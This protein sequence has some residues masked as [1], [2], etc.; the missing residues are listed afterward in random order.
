MKKS[1]FIILLASLSLGCATSFKGGWKD[2]KAY[3]NTFYNAKQ[4]YEIGLNKNLNQNIVYNPELP[5]RILEKP[6][7]GGTQE[8]D[9]AIDKSADI[10]RKHNESKWVDDAIEIIGKSYFFKQDYFSADQK[11]IELYNTSQ[12]EEKKQIAAVWK[13]RTLYEMEQTSQAIAYLREQVTALEESWQNEHLSMAKVVLAEA[14]IAEENWEAALIELEPA[15]SN[16][17]RKAYKERAYFL[18]GQLHETLGNLPKAFD[19]Y[20][21][22]ENHFTDYSLQYLAYTKKAIVARN[23]GDFDIASRTFS[24]MI[25][26]DK[27][28]DKKSELDYEL[29]RT[30]QLRGNYQ[31]AENIYNKLLRG[32]LVAPGPITSAKTYYSLAE[33]YRF[34]YND[35]SKAAAYY[36]SAAS[37]N[38]PANQL[39]QNFNPN[40]L[41]KSFGEYSRVK[42]EIALKDSLLSLGQLSEE[43]FEIALERIKEQRRKELEAQKAQEE[44]QRNTLVNVDS[45]PNQTN[46]QSFGF[47]NFRNVQVVNDSK[48]QFFAI[49][50]ERRLT[51]NWRVR[52]TLSRQV[53]L[54]DNDEAEEDIFAEIDE[55]AQ[56]LS[57]DLS[58]IPFSEPQQTSMRLELAELNYQLGNI[59]YLS[60]NMP[61]SAAIYFRKVIEE[62]PESDAKPVSY[63]SLAELYSIQENEDEAILYA[64]LLIS[65]YPETRFASRLA[66]KYNLEE[67]LTAVAEDSTSLDFKINELK[68]NSNLSRVQVADSLSKL[69]I[70]NPGFDKSPVILFEATQMYS[71]LAKNDSSY[72]ENLNVWNK[73]K[74][75]W[76]LQ[77]KM[78]K[79]IQDSANVALNK[80]SLSQDSVQEL[81]ALKDSVLTPPD[82]ID[83]FPY[84]GEL[85]DKARSNLNSFSLSFANS[86]LLSAVKRLQQELE[87]PKVPE[88]PLPQEAN[89]TEVIPESDYLNCK[90]LENSVIIRGGKEEFLKKVEFP[91]WVSA[92]ESTGRISFQFYINTR[93]ILDSYKLVSINRSQDLLSAFDEAFKSYLVF[94]PSLNNGEAVNVECSIE[95]EIQK[96][97]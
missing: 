31:R 68:K 36:D 73:A 14:L 54:T 71:N 84:K 64:D 92:D 48:A 44:R 4:N 93:G 90:E 19:A 5:I 33:I 94:E 65:N 47:L 78:F 30:E 32:N 50:G 9:N 66:E 26:D 12:S 74:Q 7:T 1:I 27:N 10:L 91:D 15:I 80:D 56:Q 96:I 55:E 46:N 52:E 49:W 53:V 16:L 18:V 28:L 88:A 21:K 41:S 87:I 63:Y 60:L 3:Y 40:E 72:Q 69:A 89:T 79:E 82:F 70:R 24:S 62:F 22:V 23:L 11:F 6:L 38:A 42:S 85:W 83:L 25:K 61:D 59:F 57:I 86:S 8:F 17:P 37:V 39:P 45:N 58:V 75:D 43:D 97:E 77:Q 29:G 76:K 13:G 20:Q 67:R 81:T 2:F 34:N 35:F 51:D 95:F